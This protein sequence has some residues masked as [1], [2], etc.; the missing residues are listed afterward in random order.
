MTV[1]S[2]ENRFK[3]VGLYENGHYRL[4]VAE[5][6]LIS[7]ANV[8]AIVNKFTGVTEVEE[9]MLPKALDY[10]DQLGAAMKEFELRDD[11]K[12]GVTKDD[13]ISSH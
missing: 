13:S 3:Q 8:Y 11:L 10:L 1:L 4:Q 12:P 5:S 6:S 7:G 9:S 2:M